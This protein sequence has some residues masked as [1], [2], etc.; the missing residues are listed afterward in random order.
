MSCRVHGPIQSNCPC[1]RR[2]GRMISYRI[3]VSCRLQSTQISNL[4]SDR[5]FAITLELGS[6]ALDLAAT[7]Y[8]PSNVDCSLKIALVLHTQHVPIF[9]FESDHQ[10][11]AQLGEFL[12]KHLYE[13][14][15]VLLWQYRHSAGERSHMNLQTDLSLRNRYEGL[16]RRLTL[17]LILFMS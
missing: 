13:I 17:T 8:S 7:V 12:A 3:V 2:S 6:A 4:P 11:I 1:M 16:S 5:P 14:V 10:S 15:V 9:V